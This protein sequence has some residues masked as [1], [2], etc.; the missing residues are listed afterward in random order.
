MPWSNSRPR[1]RKYDG[2]HN[3]KVKQ[4]HVELAQAGF[5]YCAEPRCLERSRVIVPGMELHL[6]HDTTGTIVLGLSHAQCNRVEAAKRARA[7]QTATRLRW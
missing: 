4:A 2:E 1:S 6:S 5:G 3:R 7:G